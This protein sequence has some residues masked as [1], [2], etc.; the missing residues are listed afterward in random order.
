M[1]D[2]AL[3]LLAASIGIS[4]REFALGW[5]EGRQRYQLARDKNVIGASGYPE[6]SPARAASQAAVAYYQALND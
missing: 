4:F 5:V 6:R 2:G 3:Q 1:N